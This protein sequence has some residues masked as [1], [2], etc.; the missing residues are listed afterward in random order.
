MLN[1]IFLY[2]ND[3]QPTDDPGL[4]GLGDEEE[5]DEKKKKEEEK[6]NDDEILEDEDI[7]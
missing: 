5:E 7:E 4:S 2:P 1:D 6:D 3:D